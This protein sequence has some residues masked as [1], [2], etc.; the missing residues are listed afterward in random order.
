MIIWWFLSILMVV[1]H[2]FGWYFATRI[3]IRIIHTDADPEGQND[4]IGSGSASLVKPRWLFS[5]DI[6]DREATIA[7]KLKLH[8][9]DDIVH[10]FLTDE[11]IGNYAG[12]YKIP[13]SPLP[14]GEGEVY[15]VCGGRISSCEE[16][17]G[18]SRLWGKIK[19]G[20]GSYFIFPMILW[21][22]GR[23]SRAE[24]GL[25]VWGRNQD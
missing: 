1:F 8:I 5:A 11:L 6:P 9:K 10:V 2:D 17:K 12:V 14:W 15:Q 23:I 22:L 18:I 25:A 19:R 4:P 13:Y 21:L 16:G 24:G 20:R 3:R 7:E